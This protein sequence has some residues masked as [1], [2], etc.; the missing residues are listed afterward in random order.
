ML[1]DD[2]ISAAAFSSGMSPLVTPSGSVTNPFA[3]DAFG[4]PW[5]EVFVPTAAQVMGGYGVMGWATAPCRRRV[6]S[7]RALRYRN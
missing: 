5:G 1:P 4:S 3:A 2:S 6:P 7:A